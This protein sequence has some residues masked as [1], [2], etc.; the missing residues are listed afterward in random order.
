[1]ADTANSTIRE[2]SGG[3]TV[4]TLAGTAGN[5][6]TIDGAGSV[7]RFYQPSG[8]AVDGLGNVYVADTLNQTIRKLTAAGVVT[9]IAGAP[10]SEGVILG[11]LPGSLNHPVGI[12]LLAGSGTSLIVADIAENSILLVTLQ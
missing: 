9:T 7:A 2:I 8:I 5:P 1:M 10:R 12:A 3:T 4:T 6:G 11:P